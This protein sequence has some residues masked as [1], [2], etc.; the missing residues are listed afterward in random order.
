MKSEVFE[1][2]KKSHPIIKIAV[3]ISPFFHVFPLELT[4]IIAGAINHFNRRQTSRKKSN[5]FNRLET[6][7]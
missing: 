5:I 2:L 1:G 3:F 4:N 6:I 7:N